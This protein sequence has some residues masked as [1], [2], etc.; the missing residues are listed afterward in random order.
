MRNILIISIAIFI[1]SCGNDTATKEAIS[2]P[3]APV[4][5]AERPAGK[6]DPVCEMP[7]DKAWTEQTIYNGDTIIFCS[8]TCKKAFLGRPSKYTKHS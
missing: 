1:T 7:F 8:E 6:I 4:A 5:K 2:I 3:A